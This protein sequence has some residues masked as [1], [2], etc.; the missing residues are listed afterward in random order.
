MGVG[1]GGGGRGGL[2]G[3]SATAVSRVAS[4]CRISS[5]ITSINAN[6]TPERSRVWMWRKKVEAPPTVHIKANWLN[7][8][9]GGGVRCEC[10]RLFGVGGWARPPHPQNNRRSCD[11]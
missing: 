3:L 5:L 9:G 10:G 2:E 6:P 1:G 7:P 8:L 11:R 4:P